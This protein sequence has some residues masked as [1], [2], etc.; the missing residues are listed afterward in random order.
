MFIPPSSPIIPGAP[1][2]PEGVRVDAL[3]AEESAG[4]EFRFRIW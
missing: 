3:P 2:Q 4:E 1:G